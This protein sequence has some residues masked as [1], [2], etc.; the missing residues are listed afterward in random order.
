MDA[1][2][3]RPERRRRSANLAAHEQLYADCPRLDGVFFPG[4]DP[5]DNHPSD[6]MPFLAEIAERLARHHPEARVWISPQGFH[7]EKLDT[8]F[9]WIDANKPAWLG[10]VVGGPGSP[11]LDSLRARL[12]ARYQLRDYPDITHIIRCCIRCSTRPGL[13]P[14]PRSRAGHGAP[15]LSGE[16]HRTL[17]SPTAS[18]YSDGVPMTRTSALGS[19]AGTD[20][21]A[22]DIMI[23][24]CRTFFR[25]EAEK[26]ADGPTPWRTTGGR[27]ATAAAWRG[28][29]AL[30]GA[31]PRIRS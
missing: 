13:R 28:R 24:Y 11:P 3:L 14:D 20:R 22:R 26:A 1:R 31:K 19:S 30:A 23:E 2:R 18:R 27:C 12:D 16:I 10:G 9:A 21:E 25:P 17:P 5:G 4:G 7:G 8:M 29:R 6:V 15:G